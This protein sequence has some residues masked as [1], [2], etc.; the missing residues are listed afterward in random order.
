[1]T[2]ESF[3][4]LHGTA[5]SAE[6]ENGKSSP[7]T[8]QAPVV[9]DGLAC[10]AT[11][12]TVLPQGRRLVMH[13]IL[14]AVAV[15]ALALPSCG[16]PRRPNVLWIVWD[17]ARADHLGLYGADRET[18]PFLDE[19]ARGAR[20]FDDCLSTAGYTLPS[21][22]SMFTGLLPSEHCADN[23]TKRLDDRYTTIAEALGTVGYQTY[24]YSANPHISS[25][26]NFQ[27]GFDVAEYPWS[28]QFVERAEAIVRSKLP[29]EDESSE[30]GA[31]F[32]DAEQGQATLSVWNIKAAGELAGEAALGWLR[33]ID[34][35]RPFFV[36]LNYMEA[37]RP[38]I[39]P[40][41]FRERTMS[42]EQIA[43]SYRVDRSWVPMW[44]YTFGLRDFTEEEIELTRAT[45]DA[46]LVELDELFRN[47]IGSLERE[48]YLDDTVVILT[49][50]HGEHL[51]EQHMLDHQYSVYQPLLRVPLV[52]HYPSRFAPGRELSPVMNFDIFPTL[53]ELAG[54]E[55]PVGQQQHAVSL[56]AAGAERS[57]FAEESANSGVGIHMVREQHPD[58]DPSPWQRRLR[59]WVDGRYKY[60]WGSDERRELY[61]LS[62][63]PLEQRDLSLEQTDRL[64]SMNTALEAYY[65]SLNLCDPEP[66]PPIPPEQYERLK[67]LGYVD[68]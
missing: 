2:P 60:I 30:L 23:H 25:A 20:V 46:T 45:Y 63:D 35:R 26:G 13:W 19:W 8:S 7:N 65:A 15:A 54:A 28:P 47:L 37:H 66:S 55:P 9:R 64:Q 39:P 52:V 21:H 24:L 56:L 1:M 50:D 42:P 10:Y 17:T 16:R 43:E 67:G 48:G 57:R 49:A 14:L 36:F 58:W 4:G 27:Q 62:V 68:P 53:L 5:G 51:G 31:R 22:A 29:D 12:V 59:S 6:P 34:R 11:S 18:T 44:E 40:R 33:S 3:T 61:D 38:Y 41:R 32:R